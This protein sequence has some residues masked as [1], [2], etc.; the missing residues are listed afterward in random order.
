MFGKSKSEKYVSDISISQ[1]QQKF[2]VNQV[3]SQLRKFY[4]NV[5]PRKMVLSAFTGSGKTTVTVKELIPKFIEN[6][7][8]KDKRVIFFVAPTSE[9]VKATYDMAKKSLDNKIVSGNLVKVFNADT[10]N[11]EKKDIARYGKSSNLS[12]DVVLV[13]L[14]ASYFY[15]NYDILTA[16]GVDLVIVDEAHLMFGTSDK[17]D[18]LANKGVY[19]KDFRAKILEKLYAMKDTANLF[20]TATPTKSQK[21]QTDIGKAENVYLRSM[22]RDILT[23]PF[24]QMKSYMDFE[25]TL[26]KGMKDFKCQCDAIAEKMTA[27]DSKTWDAVTGIVPTY[28]ALL[29][30]TGRNGAVNGID[31]SEYLPLIRKKCQ[32]YGFK[33]MVA[34]S[35]IS[36]FEGKKITDLAHAVEIGSNISDT[37]VVLV[38]IESGSAGMDYVKLNNVIIAR[39]PSTPIFNNWGQTAGR[40]ARMKF[41]FRDH[42]EAIRAIRDCDVSEE[43]KLLLTEYYVLHST[44]TIHV[45]VESRVLNVDVKAF[46]ETDTFRPYAG[47]EYMLNGVFENGVI[48]VLKTKTILEEDSYKLYRKTY[49]EVCNDAGDG[50]TYCYKAAKAGFERQTGIILETHEMDMLWAKSLQT[51]HL[52]GNHFNRSPENEK[53][54]CPSAH[55]VFTMYNEDYN[56]RYP[57]IRQMLS[58]ISKKKNGNPNIVNLCFQ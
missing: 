6:F 42:V 24:F 37:P 19:N 13:V 16:S 45:P 43:Q 31:L 2:L 18:T 39:S 50:E 47:R 56:N 10:I 21:T 49:C 40:A 25:D 57:E 28:P 33:F 48:P 8:S 9:V 3:I 5:D 7:T 11:G 12:A 30:K 4:D 15:Y 52:D 38:V 53:T 51:H 1:D 44:S 20:L 23:S 14:T 41:G 58:T 36:E 27:I 22:P 29:I 54:L 35:A 17:E 55:S 46:I 32:E 34:T 26:F